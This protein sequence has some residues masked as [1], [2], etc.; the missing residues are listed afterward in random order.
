MKTLCFVNQ[1]GG[2]GK[3][4]S[5]LNIGAALQRQGRRVLLVDLDAQGSLTKSAGIRALDS[6][7]VTVSEVLSGKGTAEEAIVRREDLPDIL[8]GDIRLS[9]TEVE[10][11]GAAGRDFILKEALEPVA[12]DYDYVLIDCSPSLSVLTLMALTASDGIII[13]VAAQYMPLDGIMQ[14]MQTVEIVRRRMN[15]NLKISGVIVT[16]YDARRGL[17]KSVY[18]AIKE[19]FPDEIFT[20]IVRYN[21]KIA[22]APTFGKDIFAYATGSIGAVAYRNIA[23]EIRR[24]EEK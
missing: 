19:K 9:G 4:T 13:P 17:D 11:I 16:L 23:A 8:P 6:E 18:E 15:P 10:L 2:V 7:A 3:T 20:D 21:S 14:L 24:R 22:E 5:C 12:G 1:K